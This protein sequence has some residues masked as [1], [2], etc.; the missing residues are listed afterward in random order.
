MAKQKLPV[1]P[2]LRALK[3]AGVD[4]E[5]HPYEYVERGGTRASSEALGVDEHSVIKTLVMETE[6]KSALLV[7][8]HGD[9]EV[10]SKALARALGVKAISPCDARTAE[11]HTGYRFGGTSPFGTR[12]ALPVYAETTVLALPR[13]WI[14]GG[15][16]GLL[17]SLDPAQLERVVPVSPVSVARPR[18]GE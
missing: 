1:T 17:V 2:A 11:R 6:A 8:M 14:N 15:R 18:G 13:I 5:L 9:A 3:R 4:F 10:S 16:Q 12:K 7:L